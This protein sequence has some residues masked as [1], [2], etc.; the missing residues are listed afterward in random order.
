MEQQVLPPGLGADIVQD[1]V[2]VLP[3][4]AQG[5]VAERVAGGGL[6]L[7]GRVVEGGEEGGFEVGQAGEVRPPPGLPDSE[8]A[9]GDA[10][11]RLAGLAELDHE[12][13]DHGQQL[14]TV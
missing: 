14:R 4:V 9:E 13:P 10:A 8:E 7:L 12:L 11:V 3:Q 1:E 6:H 2:Q 5:D